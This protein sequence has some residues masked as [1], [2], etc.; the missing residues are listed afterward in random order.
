VAVGGVAVAAALLA[1]WGAAA[2]QGS[3]VALLARKGE[4]RA[5]ETTPRA[6]TR[7]RR[8]RS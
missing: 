3:A 6:R 8:S 7:C 1:L 4:L 5:V 2:H